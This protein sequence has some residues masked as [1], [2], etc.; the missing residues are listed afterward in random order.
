MYSDKISFENACL[1]IG[2]MFWPGDTQSRLRQAQ[3]Q[4]KL[5]QQHINEAECKVSFYIFS[6]QA[7]KAT[8]KPRRIKNVIAASFSSVLNTSV[9][10]IFCTKAPG[11]LPIVP[12]IKMEMK[13]FS[14]KIYILY[15]SFVGYN[16]PSYFV[17]SSQWCRVGGINKLNQGKKK[18]QKKVHALGKLP[19]ANIRV[20]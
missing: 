6:L 11:N 2:Y 13:F 19:T 9:L 8:F 1:Q 20:R 3:L 12:I 5:S 10:F 16:G 14:S 18:N 4:Q 7:H 15:C 17:Y